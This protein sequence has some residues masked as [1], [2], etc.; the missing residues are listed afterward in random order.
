[1]KRQIG[2]SE[3]LE[4]KAFEVK[5]S[6][7]AEHSDSFSKTPL[8][9]K[10]MTPWEGRVK[11][12]IGGKEYEADLMGILTMGGDKITDISDEELDTQLERSSYWRVAF[13]VAYSEAAK[14]RRKAELEFE[15]WYSEVSEGIHNK[16]QGEREKEIEGTRRTAIG[17][18][19]QAQV[20]RGVVNTPA[21]RDMYIQYKEDISRLQA[22]ED[23]LKGIR[24]AIQDRG[25]HLMGL[26]RRRH[27]ERTHER[28]LVNS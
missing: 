22:E 12:A 26:A 23:K 10:E 25:Q 24:D 20:Q 16:I 9:K 6:G 21:Y 15:V 27:E 7:I 17:Q 3:G 5:K 18:I 2:I 11:Y 14:D 8:K 1:L 13:L 28:F 4:D 19:T